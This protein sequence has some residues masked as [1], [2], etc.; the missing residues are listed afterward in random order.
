MA[1]TMNMMWE[2]V[3]AEQYDEVRGIVD[4]ESN[5]PK[6]AISHVA[7][8][9]PAYTPGVEGALYVTDIWESAADFDAFVNDRLMPAVMKVGISTEPTTVILDTHNTFLPAPAKVEK[10]R[11]PLAGAAR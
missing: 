11:R 5:I 3:T 2:G 6:G 10:L 4:W 7:S 1:I 8:F 9:G